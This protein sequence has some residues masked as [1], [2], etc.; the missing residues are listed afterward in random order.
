MTF[1]CWAL[2]RRC[3]VFAVFLS[4]TATLWAEDATNE[5]WVEAES[6]DSLGG[7]LID[8]QSMDQMGSAY[9]MAHGIGVPVED[10]KGTVA[11]P[12]DGVWQVWVR[13]RDWTAPWKRGNP[14]GTFKLVV[15]GKTLP[16][17]LGTNGAEWAWQKAGAVELKKG[18]NELVLHDLTGFNG[19][20]DAIYFTKDPATQPPGEKGK[21]DDFRKKIA[22]IE[23]KD[24]PKVYD[25]AVAGGG[26]S[27]MCTA[28]AA[29]RTGSQVV[30]IQDRP[31]LGGNNS[32]EI[33]V[34]MGGQTHIGLYPNLGNVVRE[35]SPIYGR[36]G[37]HPTEYYEDTRKENVFRTCSQC[38]LVLNTRVIGV[39]RDKNDPQ[40]ITAYIARDVK[41]G[42]ETRFRAKLFADCT[43]DAVIARMMGA[44]VMRGR[45]SRS[46]YNE[47]LAPVKGDEQVMGMSVMWRS[48]KESAPTS[49]PDIDWGIEFNEDRCYYVTNGDWEWETGQYRDQATETEY[50]RD[51]GLMT[52]FGNWSYLKNHSKRKTEWANDRIFWVSPMGGKRESYRVVGDYILNQNDIEKGVIYPDATC[53]L[54]WNLD[55]HWP[56]PI[57]EE[58]FGEPFRSCAYHRNLIKPYPIPYRCLYAKDVKNLFLAGRHVSVSH[59]AFGSARVM[60][61]CGLFGEV[62]GLAATIC[63]KEDI[64]PRDVYESR[65]DKLKVM[66]EKGVPYAPTYH[67][68][69]PGAKYEGYHFKDTGHLGVYPH[70]SNKLDEPSVQKRIKSLGVEHYSYKVGEP[71]KRPEADGTRGLKKF[72][73]AWTDATRENTKAKDG[74]RFQEHLSDSELE[75]IIGNQ[76]WD[77]QLVS[78]SPL[79]TTITGLKPGVQYEVDAI[80]IG[81]D[82]KKNSSMKWGIDAGFAPGKLTNFTIA[83]GK[84]VATGNTTRVGTGLQLLAPLGSIAA[85]K[86]GKIK[87]YIGTSNYGPGSRTRYDGVGY[88]EV[89]KP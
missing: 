2:T 24:D 89:K 22:K 74:W 46:K 36:P 17:T 41:T 8:Q 71:A 33:R 50:I 45:E 18:Q 88:K 69:G 7:W 67:T 80:F 79:E 47:S 61:T 19:R 72:F 20:C 54:T 37:I 65:F 10:A 23:R 9:I 59:V 16:E 78:A 86:E 77:S 76:V 84:A 87:V 25:L 64:Y 14:G 21:L 73:D 13:T 52:I 29:A 53:S 3:F 26:V 4:C 40:K 58:K 34:P 27:G 38:K 55:L 81:I 30:L 68:G 5:V 11:I 35:V 82:P 49:F 75:S 62:V 57:H 39:E 32:S 43:G 56:D 28:L 1:K 44:E 83:N 12:S 15:D 31:V 70:R 42:Q 51:Y 63:A 6:L 85:D 66:M 60:R 48:K